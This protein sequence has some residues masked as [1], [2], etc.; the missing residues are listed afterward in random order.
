MED[1]AKRCHHN[2]HC[3]SQSICNQGISA[4][5]Q[6]G[7]PGCLPSISARKQVTRSWPKIQHIDHNINRW[8]QQSHKAEFHL[9]PIESHV[10]PLSLSCPEDA[11]AANNGW[12]H[13]KLGHRQHLWWLQILQ[14]WDDGVHCIVRCSK[15]NLHRIPVCYT[16]T[17]ILGH[18]PASK[19]RFTCIWLEEKLKG[20][21]NDLPCN[22][23]MAFCSDNA[24]ALTLF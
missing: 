14:M 20:I 7:W 3:K 13:F 24:A 15:W 17:Y 1:G 18:S 23:E 11:D 4:C 16:T 8:M 22:F 12:P 2:A 9:L 6:V 10:T 5:L 19:T 21:F